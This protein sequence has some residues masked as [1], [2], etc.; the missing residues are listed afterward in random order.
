LVDSSLVMFL[1]HA[2]AVYLQSLEGRDILSG[3]KGSSQLSNFFQPLHT[4][5][6]A[7]NNKNTT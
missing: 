3:L 6:Y 4:K 7:D 5:I 1:G 2:H